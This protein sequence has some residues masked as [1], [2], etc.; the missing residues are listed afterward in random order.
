MVG[1]EL[2]VRSIHTKSRIIISHISNVMVLILYNIRFRGSNN[3]SISIRSDDK[4]LVKEDNDFREEYINNISP[5]FDANPN[6]MRLLTDDD[7][8]QNGVTLKFE[9]SAKYGRRSIAE[10]DKSNLHHDD[11]FSLNLENISSVDSPFELTSQTERISAKYGRRS[12]SNQSSRTSSMSTSEMGDF[13]ILN[14]RENELLSGFMKCDTAAESDPELTNSSA[15][16]GRRAI[17]NNHTIRVENVSANSHKHT[18]DR[19]CSAASSKISKIPERKKSTVEGVKYS[20]KTLEES[21]KSL[22]AFNKKH[23]GRISEGKCLHFVSS[24]K[25]FEICV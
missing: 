25:K 15:R 17:R 4:R 2:Q 23:K 9:R 1:Y 13:S 8:D 7:E 6:L 14:I 11:E 22:S 24:C 10:S 19:R 12:Q 3:K 5:P 21:W 16:Y 20:D 18:L